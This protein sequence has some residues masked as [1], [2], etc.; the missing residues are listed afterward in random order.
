MS[1][2]YKPLSREEIEKLSDAELAARRL[3][4]ERRLAF[5]R[6]ELEGKLESCAHA[7]RTDVTMREVYRARAWQDSGHEGVRFEG[8]KVIGCPAGW[9]R[10]YDEAAFVNRRVEE[11]MADMRARVKGLFGGQALPATTDSTKNEHPNVR[12]LREMLQ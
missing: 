6:G 9:P 2:E 7:L 4:V 11:D 8:G 10:E 5:L 1:D 3:E 12:R